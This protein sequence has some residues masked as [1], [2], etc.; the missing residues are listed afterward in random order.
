[1]KLIY[2]NLIMK[3]NTSSVYELKSVRIFSLKFLVV[4]KLSLSTVSVS[5]SSPLEEIYG[6][7]IWTSTLSAW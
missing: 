5:L 4:M 7:C 1:M 2:E 6:V 3:I